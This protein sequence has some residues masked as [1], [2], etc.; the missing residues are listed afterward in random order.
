MLDEPTS[1][2]DPL[3]EA[4][5]YEN[6]HR[7]SAGRTTIF[8]SHRMSSSRFSDKIVVFGQG[9]ICAMGTHE[10]LMAREGLYKDLFERQAKGYQLERG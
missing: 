9:R 8:V 7:L 4:D 3:A 1:A 5:L 2:L 6:L 10:E